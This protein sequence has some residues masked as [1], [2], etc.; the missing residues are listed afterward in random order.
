MDQYTSALQ[1]DSRIL[2]HIT[3]LAMNQ[4]TSDKP[5]SEDKTAII[6]LKGPAVFSTDFGRYSARTHWKD[7]PVQIRSN[8]ESDRAAFIASLRTKFPEPCMKLKQEDLAPATVLEYFD[9]YDIHFYSPTF[10]FEVLGYMAR[11]NDTDRAVRADKIESF[12]VNWIDTNRETFALLDPLLQW[13]HLF[14]QEDVD[15][16]GFP[17]VWDAFRRIV[18]FSESNSM[19]PIS[20]YEVNANI[21]CTLQKIPTIKNV[22][23]AAKFARAIVHYPV[24]RAHQP[25]NATHQLLRLSLCRLSFQVLTYHFPQPCITCN[26]T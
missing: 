21:Y 23:Y 7:Q 24:P 9:D 19:G 3:A 16:H 17:F 15:T 20:R 5:P 6:S 1:L 10:L 25:E 13:Y 4:G 2:A 12:V 22:C 26:H 8:Y 18:Q 14:Q 11:A